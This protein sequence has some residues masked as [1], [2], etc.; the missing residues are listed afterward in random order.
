MQTSQLPRAISLAAVLALGVVG[1]VSAQQM[2]GGGY[3]ALVPKPAVTSET[4][5]GRVLQMV[6][7][8]GIVFGDEE[9]NPF[10]MAT[11]SCSGTVVMA[12]DGSDLMAKGYC[13]GVDLEGDVWW[14]SWEETAAGGSWNLLGG[15]GKFE[16]VSGGGQTSRVAEW[17]D[18]RYVVRWDGT[19]T[20]K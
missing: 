13:D 16:G 1:S 15:T 11:Q 17:P 12:A 3:V 20:M 5:D 14:I 9:S 18:G 6:G 19:W 7:V 4:P 2:S 8:D 10:G